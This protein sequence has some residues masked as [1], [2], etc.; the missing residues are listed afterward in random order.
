MKACCLYGYIATPINDINWLTLAINQLPDDITKNKSPR[1]V[2][3]PPQRQCV[4]LHHYLQW[5]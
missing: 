2:Q 1:G 3:A 5:N 4:V